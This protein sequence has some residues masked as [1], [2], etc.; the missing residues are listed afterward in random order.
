MH[1]MTTRRCLDCP[2]FIHAGSRCAPCE[3]AHRL[4]WA[5]SATRAARLADHPA[6]AVCRSPATKL[7]HVIP[8][9]AGSGVAGNLQAL[10]RA[11]H[12]AKSTAERR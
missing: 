10:C 2:T 9:S 3:R 12:R 1:P 7:D 6:C 8:R 5:W 4:G 11:C